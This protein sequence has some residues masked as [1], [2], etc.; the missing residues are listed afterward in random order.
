MNAASIADSCCRMMM[1][2]AAAA[3]KIQSIKRIEPQVQL[4]K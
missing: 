1:N 3:A 4:M 2:S